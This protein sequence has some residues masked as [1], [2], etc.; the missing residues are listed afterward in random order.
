[1]ES[2]KK[3]NHP[4][5]LTF[6]KILETP[7]WTSFQNIMYFFI[8]IVIQPSKYLGINIIPKYYIFFYCYRHSTIQIS[9]HL[10]NI[11]N[12]ILALEHLKDK[13]FT[14]EETCHRCRRQ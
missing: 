10:Y 9:L 2:E 8:V 12:C 7:M 3:V 4:H 1:M 14:M 6:I 5:M 11:R 13:T